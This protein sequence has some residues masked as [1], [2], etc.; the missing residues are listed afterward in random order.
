MS[1]GH[2]D[3]D[4]I[5]SESANHS[6]PKGEVKLF[7][8][9]FR[10]LWLFL[11]TTTT[12]LVLCLFLLWF[13]FKLPA[14]QQYLAK[15]ATT[16]LSSLFHTKMT[17]D[18]IRIHLFDR[19]EFVN[20]YLEDPQ[21][22]TIIW[23][24]DLKA[25]FD[26]SQI[27][28]GKLT[29]TRV[30]LHEGYFKYQRH[31][32][33]R[34]FNLFYF[35]DFLKPNKKKKNKDPFQLAIQHVEVYNSRFYMYDALTGTTVSVLAD[36]GVV[37]T[38]SSDLVSQKVYADSVFFDGAQVVVKIDKAIPLVL[39]ET[40]RDTIFNPPNWTACSRKINFYNLDFQLQNLRL[41]AQPQ[42]P[43]D[44]ADLHVKKA[45]VDFSN[46]AFKDFIIQTKINQ[47][48]GIEKKGFVLSSLY[49][50][51]KVSST[52]ASLN[53]F[54]LQTPQSTIGSDV[55]F[56]Y[57]RYSDFLD[58]VHKVKIEATVTESNLRISDLMFFAHPLS[59]VPF[60]VSNQ[61][62]D[63]LVDCYFEGRID[64]FFVHSI[65]MNVGQ[66][67]LEGE[68]NMRPFDKFMKLKIEE[69]QT[70]S[71]EI[72]SILPFV[73]IPPMVKQLGNIYANGSFEGYFN[74]EFKVIAQANT[75][76]GAVDLQMDMDASGGLHGFLYK[77]V[78]K[79]KSIQLGKLVNQKDLGLASGD[80]ILSGKGFHLDS[81]QLGIE[82]GIVSTFQFKGYNY[83]SIQLS[84]KLTGKKFTGN[85]V[86]TDAH[87]NVN[88]DTE[89]D[90][91]QAKPVISVKGRIPMIDFC[92]I[93]LMNDDLQ[94]SVQSVDL[95]L[96]GLKLDEFSG[97]VRLKQIHFHRGWGD[98]DVDS[99]FVGTRDTV[100]GG[101][102]LRS[103]RI[104]S[105]VMNA[106]VLGKYDLV[107]MPKALLVFANEYYP[108]F[109]QN[110]NEV[111]KEGQKTDWMKWLG[112]SIPQQELHLSLQL[113][114]SKKLTEIIHPQ[115]KFIRGAKLN[116]D[117]NSKTDSFYI[118]AQVDSM[119]WG[120]FKLVN[121][122]L[123][124]QGYK[125]LL[126]ATNTMNHLQ[127]NDSLSLPIPYILLEGRGDSIAFK[128]DLNE[129]GKFA[130]NINLAGD[131][132]ATQKAIFIRL[133]NSGLVLLNQR[134]KVMGNNYIRFDFANNEL[135]VNDLLLS[136]SI[137]LQK[138]ELSSYGKSGLKLGIKSFDL[139]RIYKPV[140]LPMFDIEGR[141]H[142][143]A[144]IQD[145]FQQ[146][147]LSAS[148]L[149]DSLMINGDFWDKAQVSLSAKTPK[150]TL[151]GHFTHNGTWLEKAE[152]HFYF[153]PKSAVSDTAKQN[154]LDVQFKAKNANTRILEYLMRGIISET[155]GLAQAEG[156]I[157]GKLPRITIQ[158]KGSIQ[159][160]EAKL[161]F[162]NT[163]YSID[164]LEVALTPEAFYFLPT[165]Q[166]DEISQMVKSGIQVKD[167][168][169]AKGF[170]GGK[171][172]HKYLKEWGIDLDLYLNKN[173]TLNTTAE[174]NMPFY[175][176]VYASG[177]A[178]LSG[179]FNKLVLEMEG[180]T[181]S[182]PKNEKSLFVLPLMQA[183][184]INQ[185][186]DYLEFRDT[187][188][189]VKEDTEL[190]LNPVNTAGLDIR[191]KIIANPEAHAKIIIDEKAGDVIEGKGSGNLFLRYSPS[192]ELSLSGD[193][194]IL[195]GSYLFTYRGLLN[196]PF[197]VEK[198]GMI[199]WNGDPYNA[200]VN[201]KAKYI[202]KSKLYNL[203]ISYQDQ[204]QNA[205]VRDDA[206]RTLDI[207]VGM[208]MT[209]P[210]MRP[211][212]KFGINLLG[213]A[214]KA[215]TIANLALKAIQQDQ[216]KLNRQVFSLIVL[217]QFFPDQN[218]ATGLNLGASSFN[219]L[220][221]MLSQ[222]FSRYLGELFNEVVEENSVISGVDV[223]IGYKLEEDQLSNSGTGSKF[224]LSFDNYLFNDKL[225]IHIGANV[226]I[227]ANNL[228]GS[229]Q[230]Y[231]GGDFIV[232]YAITK[233]GNL[234]V[235]AYNRSESSLFG[236][237]IR[238]G[239]GISYNLEFNSFEEMIKQIK[240]NIKEKKLKMIS[241]K[242]GLSS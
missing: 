58:F 175:G 60:F 144:L 204:L 88:V 131:V 41:G 36:K 150:D 123:L 82:S 23:A 114:D 30:D 149:L 179:P 75:D 97:R 227:N 129:I 6:N 167:Q 222:Q 194:E 214:G 172:T 24:S 184:E 210:L 86:S 10:Y 70:F 90:L 57:S 192:G 28:K 111:N 133:N 1:R 177:K 199:R 171:I 31:P 203:L 105:D 186:I 233:D 104:R 46:F 19:A 182:G 228:Y 185:A 49:G 153:I 17:V 202:Q 113:F 66:S 165:L 215:S 69:L 64:S 169:G 163:K 187:K 195:E 220:S 25:Y 44:F 80:F 156:R 118:K 33:Q 50:D 11:K 209:G 193:Y 9:L 240:E 154:Y 128:I 37:H 180:S 29:I 241:K 76:A 213:D 59:K 81:I 15:Q 65:I 16:E 234:K 232:E 208:N 130:Y 206:N 20:F 84:G 242:S 112:D 14:V 83:D 224:D 198:G 71:S 223:Q 102:S 12:V 74:K 101:D 217:N 211:D 164:K 103:V 127:L 126:R 176:K 4:N 235:R 91:Q 99:L 145:V 191:M 18:K 136:D 121:E 166:L 170:I 138:I 162:L 238:T 116:F 3:D 219:T 141:M 51:L 161:N 122:E 160:L 230:N 231:F 183:V 158:G 106:T 72:Q 34:S 56:S 110:I 221:E 148:V 237:R 77:G 174:S 47:F 197:K 5:R 63:V 159:G 27:L 216:N 73:Q 125:N 236:P 117:F 201:L 151:F 155:R 225:R 39:N 143:E 173:L 137:E 100:L 107:N 35:I 157:Y 239:G 13:V 2:T 142:V 52:S 94:L 62:K 93:K 139:G 98:Y 196:K 78:V 55:V 8:Q 89:I 147:N 152:A 226:D 135:E 218:A 7:S 68:I 190:K 108:N 132:R 45:R 38:D 96:R 42:L 67:H 200:E 26:I 188:K 181:E 207:E 54:N 205:E 109:T 146:K 22:D 53:N 212:I 178:N 87:F 92:A 119:K 229:N 124:V 120:S 140:K 168:E 48:A 85:L 95:R 134:W 40:S 61:E 189:T 115:F 43:M 32:G 21:K 79:G